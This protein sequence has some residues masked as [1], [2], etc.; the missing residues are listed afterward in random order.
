MRCKKRRAVAKE[1]NMSCDMD[2]MELVSAKVACPCD[3]FPVA[4]CRS[5]ASALCDSRLLGE[6]GSRCP[7]EM[8]TVHAE[9]LERSLW[10]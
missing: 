5:C 6:A 3:V 1:G 7:A 2:C 10:T 4:I 8:M 9:R